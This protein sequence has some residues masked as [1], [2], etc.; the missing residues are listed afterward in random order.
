MHT[1]DVVE[2]AERD[3]RHRE[4]LVALATCRRLEIEA[5]HARIAY[6]VAAI[7][8]RLLAEELKRHD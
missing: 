6:E 7:R 1:P 3:Q 2:N 5:E 8:V 4:L